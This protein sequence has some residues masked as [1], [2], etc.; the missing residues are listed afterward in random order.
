MAPNKYHCSSSH[1]LE[2]MW[3]ALRMTALPAL[4]NTTMSVSHKTVWPT[5]WFTASI[6]LDTARKNFI[7]CS[8]P[9][10]KP[11]DFSVTNGKAN[12][13]INPHRKTLENALEPHAQVALQGELDAARRQLELSGI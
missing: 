5:R 13:R 4:T 10:A 9:G 1:A 7:A 6:S 12:Q 8:N 11:T 3:K 2:L